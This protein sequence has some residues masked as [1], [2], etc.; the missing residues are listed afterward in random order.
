MNRTVEIKK[1]SK[2]VIGQLSD[3]NEGDQFKLY[4]PDGTQVKKGR[5]KNFTALC[6]A[7]QD[8]NNTWQVKIED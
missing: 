1:G 6:N 3:V 5:K 8:E 4:E 7:Y 2:W